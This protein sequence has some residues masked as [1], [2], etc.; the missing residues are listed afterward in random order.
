MFRYYQFCGHKQKNMNIEDLL[1][2]ISQP[3]QGEKHEFK[4]V[5]GAFAA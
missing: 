2:S 5:E 4:L 3:A 1:S